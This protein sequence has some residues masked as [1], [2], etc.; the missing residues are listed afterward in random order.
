MG[1]PNKVINIKAELE[2]AR[3]RSGCEKVGST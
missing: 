2:R 1:K 3:N